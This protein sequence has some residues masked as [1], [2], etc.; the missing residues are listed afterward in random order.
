MKKFARKTF[1][2]LILS[3]ALCFAGFSGCAF[4]DNFFNTLTSGYSVY[5]TNSD[6]CLDKGET[7]KIGYDD[8]MFVDLSE[9]RDAESIEYS[10]STADSAVVKAAGK[11]IQAMSPGTAKVT[12]T[13]E[14]GVNAYLNITVS[15]SVKSLSLVFPSGRLLPYNSAAAV[16]VYAVINGG[17]LPASDYDIRWSIN[18]ESVG[19]YG[20]PLT[21]YKRGSAEVYSVGAAVYDE[22]VRLRRDITRQISACRTTQWS[23]RKRWRIR[24]KAFCSR[25][26]SRLIMPNGI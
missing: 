20:N 14:D 8:L 15:A 6:I 23:R 18:G 2:T 12:L 4:I 21:L 17:E 13:T 7:L 25:S 26:T 11:T 5:F 9:D 3:A 19:F 22:G 1:I 16:D 24:A 10:L